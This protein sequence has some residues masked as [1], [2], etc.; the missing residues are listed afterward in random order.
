M[1]KRSH[2]LQNRRAGFESRK[3]SRPGPWLTAEQNAL[4]ASREATGDA[5]HA[6]DDGAIDARAGV[7]MIEI[8][9]AVAP[10]ERG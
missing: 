4:I 10:I 8:F 2:A 9:A 1:T 6:G 5:R 7:Q 3:E